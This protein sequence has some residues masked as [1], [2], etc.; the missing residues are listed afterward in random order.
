MTALGPYLITGMLKCCNYCLLTFCVIV[1]FMLLLCY[2]LITCHGIACYC[3]YLTPGGGVITGMLQCPLFRI[4]RKRLILLLLSDA[5]RRRVDEVFVCCRHSSSSC[6]LP[7]P[8]PL[9]YQSSSV[10]HSM[11]Q[12]YKSLKPPPSNHH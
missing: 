2:S 4:Y 7:A 9:K 5:S 3:C 8:A 11:E 12:N 6:L 10:S 1:K